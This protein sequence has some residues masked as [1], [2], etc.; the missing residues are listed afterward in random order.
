MNAVALMFGLNLCLAVVVV[1]AWR[2]HADEARAALSRWVA[3]EGLSLVDA[4]R[5]WLRR[6][7]FW[8]ASGSRAV[9]RVSVGDG[10]GQQRAGW[11]CLGSWARGPASGD[12]VTSW[13]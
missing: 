6:G 3:S 12:V 11:V 4:E 8:L 13:D 9:F 10:H 2:G 5:R 1:R 7:P